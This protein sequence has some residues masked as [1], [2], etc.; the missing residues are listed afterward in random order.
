MNNGNGTMNDKCEPKKNCSTGFLPHVRTRTS[1]KT[2]LNGF[3]ESLS[4]NRRT[5]TAFTGA[6]QN[7]LDLFAHPDHFANKQTH[8][9]NG[10]CR[11]KNIGECDFAV[12]ND[13]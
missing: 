13:T 4:G 10:L 1:L 8:V 2:A 3:P 9:S 7:L 6:G 11:A 12:G 5:L